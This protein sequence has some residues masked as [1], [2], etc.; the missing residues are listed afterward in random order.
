M[1]DLEITTE[2]IKLDSALKLASIVGSGGEAKNIIGDGYVILNGE[3]C[4]QRGKKLHPG[5]IIE[6]AGQKIK[7]TGA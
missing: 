3:P 4:T 1:E 2:F 6:V 5:D 7:I